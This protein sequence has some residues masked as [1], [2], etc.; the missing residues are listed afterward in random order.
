[1]NVSVTSGEGLP[2]AAYIS[3]RIG[4][5]RRQAPFRPNE[6]FPF[7]SSNHATMKVGVGE[8]SYVLVVP[9]CL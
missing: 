7:P 6:P 8:R 1:M 9:L 3:I 2:S 4:E 5:Q